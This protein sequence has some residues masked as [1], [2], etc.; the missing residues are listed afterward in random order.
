MAY[1]A[2]KKCWNERILLAIHNHLYYKTLDEQLEEQTYS[3]LQNDKNN[4]EM[5]QAIASLVNKH[6]DLFGP[7]DVKTLIGD[8][9]LAENGCN[10]KFSTDRQGFALIG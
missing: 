3:I 4:T 7:F 1:Q 10:L 5:R 2:V 9:T 6:R 8:R